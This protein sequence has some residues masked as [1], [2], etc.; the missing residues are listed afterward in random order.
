MSTATCVDCGDGFERKLRSL[1]ARCERCRR[2]RTNAKVRERRAQFKS[3]PYDPSAP[4]H[5]TTTGYSNR[6][7][8]CEACREAGKAYLREWNRRPEV[9]ARRLAANRDAQL[10]ARYA[11]NRRSYMYR[12]DK[13]W[14][15]YLE[16]ESRCWACGSESG[17]R[18]HVDHDHACCT[19]QRSCGKCFRGMLC[20]RCNLALGLMRDDTD[21]LRALIAYVERAGFAANADM[22]GDG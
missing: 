9:K 13:E 15:D 12:I 11:R 10:Q 1:R 22:V 19:G 17:E 20:R 3:E 7:C 5:G 14:L 18:L 6:A 21:A 16:S 2:L 4:W 8:R